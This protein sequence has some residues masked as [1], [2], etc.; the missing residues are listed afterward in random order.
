M[1]FDKDKFATYLRKHSTPHSQG[2]CARAMRQALEA[3]GAS[4]SGHPVAAKEY[5]PTLE[6][7]GFYVVGFTDLKTYV[8]VKGDVVIFE[9]H[10]GGNA[11]GHI[12][13][14]D[15]RRWISDFNQQRFWPGSGYEREEAV[16][17]VYR[18]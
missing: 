15:G 12:Q 3:G 6:R 2:R 4:T 8:P 9:P 18:R 11:A 1:S 13:A 14:Y 7:N 16:Y 10:S 5:G 17:V